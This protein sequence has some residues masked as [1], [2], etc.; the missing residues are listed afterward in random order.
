[1]SID[2]VVPDDLIRLYE[3]EELVQA[4]NLYDPSATQINQGRLQEV[5]DNANGVAYGYLAV[6][7]TDSFLQ[8]ETLPS[9]FRAAFKAH[10]INIARFYLDRSSEEIQER[11]DEAIEYF[12]WVSESN[13]LIST[14]SVSASSGV[15][16]STCKVWSA[17]RV[18]GLF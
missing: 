10:C 6:R 2:Y 16:F 13:S 11:R 14:G 12:K 18:A 15:A 3:S 8:V 4:T 7:Y 17:K 5:C 9:G 1:M